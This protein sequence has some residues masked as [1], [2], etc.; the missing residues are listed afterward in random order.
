MAPH[1]Q[2]GDLF[3]Q[4]KWSRQERMI[5]CSVLLQAVTA[6]PQAALT[7]AWVHQGCYSCP[8]Q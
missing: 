8:Q 6:M 1:L 4:E 5:Y 3:P 7:C 2:A